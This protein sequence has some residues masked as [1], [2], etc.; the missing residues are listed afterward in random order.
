M[1]AWSYALMLEHTHT[2]GLTH[3][4]TYT[5]TRTHTHTH[6]HTRIVHAHTVRQECKKAFKSGGPQ[7]LNRIDLYGKKLIP[8]EIL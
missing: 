3:T 1:Q 6:T 4:H 2:H 7:R 5:H 8:M